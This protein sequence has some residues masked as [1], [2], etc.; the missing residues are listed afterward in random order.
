[1]VVQACST[2][3]GRALILFQA[4]ADQCRVKKDGFL[5]QKSDGYLMGGKEFSSIF[6]FRFCCNDVKVR[7]V[8]GQILLHQLASS[9]LI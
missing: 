3:T 9:L 6:E 7:V 4:S 2:R 5:Y 8:L 1:V